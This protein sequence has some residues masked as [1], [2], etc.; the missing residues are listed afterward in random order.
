MRLQSLKE[1]YLRKVLLIALG[2]LL[3]AVDTSV[4]HFDI[5][6]DK[7]QIDGLDVAERIDASV[8]VDDIGVLEA[9]Y[10]VN[11]G[12][13]LT[14]IRKELISKTFA[15]G[16][17]LYQTCDVNEFESSGSELIRLIHF[18]QLVQSL[19]GDRNY[20]HVLFDSA[21]GIVC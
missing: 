19:I 5:G 20:T 16:S 21:E 7:L 11:D 12:V 3:C 4:H 15:L 13:N 6:E 9:S 18:S 2:S 17:S 8:N 1:V 14:D 10:N